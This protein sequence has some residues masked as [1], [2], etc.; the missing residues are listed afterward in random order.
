MRWLAALAVV[1][2][3]VAPARAD[4]RKAAEHFFVMGEKA[5]KAQ[6]F[7]AA[8]VDFERAYSALALPEIAFSAA[9]AYRRQYR[10]DHDPKHVKRAIDLYTKYLDKIRSGGRVA[11]AADALEEMERELA[12]LLKAG[13]KIEGV[14]NRQRTWLGVTV[15]I[16]ASETHGGMHE[17]TDAPA[18]ATDVVAIATIDGVRVQAMDQLEVAAGQHEVHAEADGFVSVTRTEA[19]AEGDGHFVDIDLLPKPARIAIATEPGAQIALDGRPKGVAPI[20]TLEMSAGKHV[21][22]ITRTGRVPILR[23]LV[24]RRGQELALDGKLVPTTR[25]RA[26][27]WAGATAVGLAVVSLAGTIVAI[28]EDHYARVLDGRFAKTGDRPPSELTRYQNDLLY[29]RTALQIAGATGVGVLVTGGIA[30]ALYFTDNPSPERVRV[31]PAASPTGAGLAVS[32][33]F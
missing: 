9:Q 25:R 13:V 15:N 24:V 20:D 29:R 2:A 26:A 30:A 21:L 33:S 10:V 4:D 5:Y 31:T 28:V 12:R 23:E 19:I 27:R 18:A 3:L 32:G 8:A 16:G 1:A 6:N 22:A 11:D 14:V 17:V 7:L